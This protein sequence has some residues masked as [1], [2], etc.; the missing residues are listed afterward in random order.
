MRRFEN[1]RV[2]DSPDPAAE[3]LAAAFSIWL[4][5]QMPAGA[6]SRSA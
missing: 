6:D 4:A 3:R 1:M 2:L 5:D